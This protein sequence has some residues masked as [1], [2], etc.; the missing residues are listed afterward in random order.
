MKI[1]TLRRKWESFPTPQI[2]PKGRAFLCRSRWRESVGG[3]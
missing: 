3:R 1:E 2:A